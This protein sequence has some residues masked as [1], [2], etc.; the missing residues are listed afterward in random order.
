MS[1]AEHAVLVMMRATVDDG[2][3]VEDCESTF[4]VGMDAA[5]AV[6]FSAFHN[7]DL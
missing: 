5:V 6:A 3:A 4:V 2:E 1:S 7:A